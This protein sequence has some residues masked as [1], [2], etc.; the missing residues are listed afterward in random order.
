[1]SPLKGSKG[2][3]TRETLNKNSKKPPN[4]PKTKKACVR[5]PIN[6]KQDATALFLRAQVPPEIVVKVIDNRWMKCDT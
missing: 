4:K 6:W 2:K 1:L 3:Y 5:S